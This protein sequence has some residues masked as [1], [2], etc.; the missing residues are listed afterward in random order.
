MAINTAEIRAEWEAR[1]TITIYGAPIDSDDAI[2]VLALCDEVDRLRAE[3]AEARAMR[4]LTNRGDWCLEIEVGTDSKMIYRQFGDYWVFV[5]GSERSFQT[6]RD[7]LA[8]L[9]AEVR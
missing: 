5:E 8:A 4:S 2:T 3:N 6:L 1:R 9:G 7:A